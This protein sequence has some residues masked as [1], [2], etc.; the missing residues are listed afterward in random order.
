MLIPTCCYLIPLGRHN[1]GLVHRD[2]SF[3]YN[4]LRVY[5]LV[6]FKVNIFCNFS[7]LLQ[8]QDLIIE[9]VVSFLYAN[10]SVSE[11][12]LSVDLPPSP[13]G[14]VIWITNMPA[15]NWTK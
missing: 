1:Y 4:K 3:S 2:A 13:R 6:I 11:R 9:R 8:V 5:I 7:L 15:L 14:A 12:V 10:S